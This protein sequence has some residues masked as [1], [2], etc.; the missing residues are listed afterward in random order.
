MA[1]LWPV[2]AKKQPPWKPVV[3][4]MKALVLDAINPHIPLAD[5]QHDFGKNHSTTTAL[6]VIHNQ[7]AR[8]MNW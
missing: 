7:I 3:K 1:E 8:G 4:L 2:A 5:H 6:H